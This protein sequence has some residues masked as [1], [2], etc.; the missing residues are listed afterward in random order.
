M[1]TPPLS[2]PLTQE[3]QLTLLYARKLRERLLMRHEKGHSRLALSSAMRMSICSP[4]ARAPERR[5]WR[6]TAVAALCMVRRRRQGHRETSSDR[7]N[8]QRPGCR[9]DGRPCLF[10]PSSPDDRPVAQVRDAGVPATLVVSAG[11]AGG[12]PDEIVIVT[13]AAALT[14]I[15]AAASERAA[16]TAAALS[17]ASCASGSSSAACGASASASA[18]CL[19]HSASAMAVVQAVLLQLHVLHDHCC[20]GG[21]KAAHEHYSAVAYSRAATAS[22]GA[23]VGRERCQSAL[24][25]CREAAR[26]RV[27]SSL[28]SPRPAAR[29]RL[30]ARADAAALDERAASMAPRIASC[31]ACRHRARPPPRSRRSN[32]A[33]SPP[34]GAL[35]APF[36]SQSCIGVAAAATSSGAARGRERSGTWPPRGGGG[37]RGVM[38]ELGAAA[39]SESRRR[40]RSRSPTAKAKAAGALLVSAAVSVSAAALLL[41]P[42]SLASSS[43]GA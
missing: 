41:W 13:G 20:S 9:P 8:S 24:A 30:S 1:E 27:A 19:V 23:Q 21:T 22:L 17:A 2:V 16:S 42:S 32:R 3:L 43:L 36:V 7:E 38:R 6:P 10:P 25:V 12:A 29:E 4:Y 37:G 34:R 15:G 18:S 11:V 26:L 40:P 14:A 35:R 28:A 31:I 39:R 5:F 33:G